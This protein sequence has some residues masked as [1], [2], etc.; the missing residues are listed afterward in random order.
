MLPIVF[1][2]AALTDDG[3]KADLEKKIAQFAAVDLKVDL[4]KLD[5]DEKLVLAHL[6][7][8]GRRL[9][10]LFLKQSWAKNAATQKTLEADKTPLGKAR[11]RLFLIFKG[12]WDRIDH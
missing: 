7:E 6:V 9:D 8:A 3:D 4:S 1:A 5:A 12:P 11:L 10:D 2:L